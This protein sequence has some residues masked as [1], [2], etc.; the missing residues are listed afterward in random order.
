MDPSDGCGV[1]TPGWRKGHFYCRFTASEMPSGTQTNHLWIP[2][3]HALLW[4]KAHRVR[5]NACEN[6]LSVYSEDKRVA[7]TNRFAG[8]SVT[9]GNLQNGSM[10]TGSSQQTSVATMVTRGE[11]EDSLQPSLPVKPEYLYTCW[12]RELSNHGNTPGPAT[13]MFK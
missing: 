13:V 12:L 7:R 3:L 5:Q 10:V 8:L 9:V 11:G 4:P 1:W 6:N 2:F